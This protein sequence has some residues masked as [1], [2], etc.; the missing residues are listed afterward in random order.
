MSKIKTPKKHGN[1]TIRE[2]IKE[3]GI[4]SDAYYL[5][6][7]N[8][9]QNVVITFSDIQSGLVQSSFK[10][11]FTGKTD[12]WENEIASYVCP[13]GAIPFGYDVIVLKR[14]GGN[15]KNTE[16][17]VECFGKIHVVRASHLYPNEKEIRFK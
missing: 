2:F 17:V 12:Y 5:A 13:I 8:C 6:T 1:L 9:G 15:I 11:D 7:C 10:C 3:S 14:A 4:N 16:Y